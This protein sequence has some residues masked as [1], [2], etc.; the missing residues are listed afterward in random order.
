MAEN[1]PEAPLRVLYL[2]RADPAQSN[3]W[4]GVPFWTIRH[5][6]AGGFA[7]TT[8]RAE[9]A[10]SLRLARAAQAA[11]RLVRRRYLPRASALHR[12]C[13]EIQIRRLLAD[14]D[15]EVVFCQDVVSAA[16]ARHPRIVY[17]CDAPVEDLWDSYL[18]GSWARI[19]N[20]RAAQAQEGEALRNAWRVLCASRWA[21][22]GL[23]RRHPEQA[24]KLVYAPFAPGLETS[25]DATEVDAAIAARSVERLRFLFVGVDW[26]RK[27]GDRAV[28]LVQTLRARGLP[29]ELTVIGA[30]PWRGAAAPPF[31]TALGFLDKS[32][33][34]DASRFLQA[35]ESAHFLLAPSRAEA[36]GIA[37]LEAHAFGVPTL[38][39]DVGG[40]PSIVRPGA[41]GFAFRFDDLGRVADEVEPW[42]RARS[43]YA[44]LARSAWRSYHAEHSWAV[45]LR[46]LT[47]L[48]SQA[49]NG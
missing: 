20:R 40:L 21:Q 15:A 42:L 43:A 10:G 48:L 37:L 36:M 28:A 19:A 26:W 6:R 14:A 45:R 12:R 16:A 34:E 27:G 41:N 29:A 46:Q 17:W 44:E 22:A 39:S 3:D 35:L 5:L 25:P 30:D 49:R 33:P 11:A 7:V 4:S 23:A 32:R 1:S 9:P 8:R 24:H 18:P 13:T 47:A 2:T 31:V 38:S